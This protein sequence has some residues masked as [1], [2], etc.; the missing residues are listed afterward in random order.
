[1]HRHGPYWL[2]HGGWAGNSGCWPGDHGR[3][4]ETVT[5]D[6]GEMWYPS[7]TWKDGRGK[8]IEIKS[9]LGLLWIPD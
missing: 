5:E 4:T 7:K 2:P 3:W 1:M 6:P 9:R 8:K